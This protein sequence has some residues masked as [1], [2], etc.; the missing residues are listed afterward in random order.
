M[1]SP[2]Q[3]TALC[4]PVPET[5]RSQPRKSVSTRQEIDH[6]H[7]NFEDL[8]NTLKLFSKEKLPAD[9]PLIREATSTEKHQPLRLIERNTVAFTPSRTERKEWTKE[10]PD[11][12]QFFKPSSPSMTK[13]VMLNKSG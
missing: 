11:S 2:Q 3:S 7:R 4:M 13:S 1:E 9:K 8:Q 6:F 10:S 12:A 5:C